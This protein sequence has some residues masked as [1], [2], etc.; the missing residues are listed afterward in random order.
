MTVV[1]SSTS[2]L[3]S[4]TSVLSILSLV[5]VACSS[6][7]FGLLLVLLHISHTFGEPFLTLQYVQWEQIHLCPILDFFSLS[8]WKR[9]CNMV[10]TRVGISLTGLALPHFCAYPVTGLLEH[11]RKSLM[12]WDL[13]TRGLRKYDYR[14]NKTWGSS[15]FLYIMIFL[16]DASNRF[17]QDS[18]YE[19]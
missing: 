10:K 3:T 18:I 4:V 5:L 7:Y 8:I 11:P 19:E 1:S 12:N 9:F 16:P 17:N 14:T 13:M 15:F 6:T 2:L